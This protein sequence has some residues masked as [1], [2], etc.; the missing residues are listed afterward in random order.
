MGKSQE[1]N[2]EASFERR[3][4]ADDIQFIEVLFLN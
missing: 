1:N 2:M 3:K 4:T